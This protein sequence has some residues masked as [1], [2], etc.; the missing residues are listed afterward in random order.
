MNYRVNGIRFSQD[1][2]DT[3]VEVNQGGVDCIYKRKMV[4]FSKPVRY[5]RMDLDGTSVKSEEFWIRRIRKRSGKYL[6]IL[7]SHYRKMTFLMYPDSQRR[8]I[9][10]IA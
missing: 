8:S 4:P 7:I 1:G 2:Q 10:P 9:Y 6:I 3:D 5:V